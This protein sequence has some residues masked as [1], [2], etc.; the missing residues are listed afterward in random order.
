M[1]RTHEEKLSHISDLIRISKID[2]DESHMELNFINYVADRLGVSRKEVQD[3]Y[4]G[5]LNIKFKTPKHEN[6]VIDQFHR[7]VLL[8]G[9]DKM[10]T[11]EELELCF[12]LGVKMGLNY[13][14][15]M[16]VLKK[17]MSNPAF[18]MQ[19]KEMEGIFNK[20]RN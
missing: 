6:Q 9:I 4:Q 18:I 8:V 7:I 16:E 17:T 14:A 10:I 1:D 5:K 2:G 19:K 13:N 20:Y 12:Q 3:I 15:I 11:K